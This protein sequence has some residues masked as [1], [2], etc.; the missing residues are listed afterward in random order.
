MPTRNKKPKKIGLLDTPK[1][2][3]VN[4]PSTFMNP[5][6]ILTKK[7]T[8]ETQ[9]KE[10]IIPEYK[11]DEEPPKIIHMKH[12][13][14][15]DFRKTYTI[16]EIYDS[17][18]EYFTIDEKE[19]R[20]EYKIKQKL[21][22]IALHEVIFMYLLEMA[23]TNYIGKQFFTVFSG[24]YFARFIS[25]FSLQTNDFDLKLYPFNTDFSLNPE[26]V[27]RILQ[28]TMRNLFYMMNNS[29]NNILSFL[30]MWNIHILQP[31]ILY[32]TNNSK[33]YLQ[34]N[35]LPILNAMKSSNIKMY[36][37]PKPENPYLLKLLIFEEIYGKRQRPNIY[38]LGD[39]EIYNIEN[40]MKE[41]KIQLREKIRTMILEDKDKVID[42]AKDK[43][44]VMYVNPSYVYGVKDTKNVLPELIEAQVNIS[45]YVF[46]M[47][48]Y[49]YYYYEKKA[50]YCDMNKDDEYCENYEYEYTDEGMPK[51]NTFNS[52]ENTYLERKFKKQLKSLKNPS[53]K[54]LY[55]GGK[56]KRKTM[57]KKNKK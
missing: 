52:S 57:K 27:L 45:P 14:M 46:Y 48:S 22:F 18:I 47:P 39:I 21:L 44:S 11:K 30:E 49:R 3:N 8:Y 1:T 31:C 51:M 13:N 36:L 54:S 42:F 15:L 12:T 26:S 41:D 17:M 28:E 6:S 10:F 29:P 37:N 53:M 32:E 9:I 38:V 33:T 35:I 7:G 16:E 20:Y 19:T 4:P 34:D 43:Q 56:K 55:M 2:T 40:S 25:N 50:L 23:H 24:S 5:V